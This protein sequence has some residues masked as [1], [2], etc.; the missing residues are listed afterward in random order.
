[1]GDLTR[2]EFRS[3]WPISAPRGKVFAVLQKVETYPHWWPEVREVIPISDGVFRYR[4]RSLLPYWLEFNSERTVED[5][6]NGILE[7]RLVGELD[8][9]SRFTVM[10]DGPGAR[11]LFEEEVRTRKRSLNLLAPIARPA[12]KANHTLM[13]RNGRRGLDRYLSDDGSAPPT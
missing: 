9:F 8:G 4:V 5:E 12:F 3:V 6:R 7:A 1:M 11:V 2:Y 10:S 13:M